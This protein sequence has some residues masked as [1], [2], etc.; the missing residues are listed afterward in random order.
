MC[1]SAWTMALENRLH[2]EK[3]EGSVTH[4]RDKQL[5]REILT[6]KEEEKFEKR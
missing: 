1:C 5:G 3:K 6:K 2:Q 4:S